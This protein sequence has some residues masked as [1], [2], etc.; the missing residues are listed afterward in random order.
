SIIVLLAFDVTILYESHC[1]EPAL[2]LLPCR[3][4][5]STDMLLDCFI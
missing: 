4:L 1:D 5:S 2:L 3:Y